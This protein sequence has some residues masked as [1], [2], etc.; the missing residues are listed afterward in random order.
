MSSKS[1]I[2]LED[3]IEEISD[4][5]DSFGDECGVDWDS[6][7]NEVIAAL[8]VGMPVNEFLDIDE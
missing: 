3:A 8:P 2:Y 6:V 5:F 7:K 1:V 4:Y